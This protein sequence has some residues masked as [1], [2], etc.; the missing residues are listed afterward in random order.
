MSPVVV[1]SD[2]RFSWGVPD[3]DRLILFCKKHVGWAAEETRKLIQP[4]VDKIESGGVM[5]QTRMDSFMRY[6]D[7]IKFANVRSKRLREVLT[8]VQARAED[9]TKQTNKKPKTAA[10]DEE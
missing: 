5:Y 4:V 8:N 6:E 2:E 10:S 3:A 7:G 1:N 9:P